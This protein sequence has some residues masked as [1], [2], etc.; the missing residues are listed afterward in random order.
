[1]SDQGSE[2]NIIGTN[3]VV[4]FHYRMCEVDQDGNKKEW[5]ESSF[6]H[7]PAVY[8]HGHSNIIEGI[9]TA[10]A[11]K[12]IGAEVSVTVSP[13]DAY[14]LRQDN[15]VQR[16]PLKHVYEAA[17]TKTFKPGDIVTVQTNQGWRD[18]TVMKAGKFNLDVDFN[19]PFAG[20][21]LYYEIKVMDIREASE[22]EKHHGHAHGPGGHHH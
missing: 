6:D 1:M 4:S 10:M 21:T 17:K 3:S 2:K 5:L 16:I 20:K 15:A 13:E 8:L 22:E 11:G 12:S 18:V 7:S 14:G 19:H 9:E